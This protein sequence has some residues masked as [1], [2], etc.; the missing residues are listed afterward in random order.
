MSNHDPLCPTPTYGYRCPRCDFIAK[1]RAD[2]RWSWTM[3]RAAEASILDD[4]RA[5]VEA[6][7]ATRWRGSASVYRADVLA[8]IDGGSDA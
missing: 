5:K 8:I 3:S 1:V 6:L 2:E 4:L 7:P